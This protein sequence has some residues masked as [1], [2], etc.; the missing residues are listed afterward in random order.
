MKLDLHER[1]NGGA[2]LR[3]GGARLQHRTVYVN[4]SCKSISW[5][6]AL[7][8]VLSLLCLAAPDQS[9]SLSYKMQESEAEA[10]VLWVKYRTGASPES[11]LR[12]D[13]E[14]FDPIKI[15]KDF[16]KVLQ[17][18]VGADFAHLFVRTILH[19]RKVGPPFW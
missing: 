13:K 8:S 5:N 1:W 15:S 10:D 14:I 17:L 4:V 16:E 19:S 9:L 7:E 18:N 3:H 2:L 11:C 12:A 6:R